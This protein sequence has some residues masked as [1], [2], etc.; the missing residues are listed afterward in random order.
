MAD[1]KPSDL[2]VGIVDFFAILLP[3]AAL[4]FVGM[5]YQR[6]IFDGVILPPLGQGAPQWIAFILSSYLLGHFVFLLGSSI[7]DP[8][9]G[10]SYRKF[11]SL[12]T[13]DLLYRRAHEMKKE[14]LVSHNRIENAYKWSRGLVRLRNSA[15]AAEIDRL[16]A[17]SK[18]FRSMVIVLFIAMFALGLNG[19][20]AL[21]ILTMLLLYF[22]LARLTSEEGQLPDHLSGFTNR[23]RFLVEKIQL[24]KKTSLFVQVA[25][26]VGLIVGA[27][28]W[29][30]TWMPQAICLMLLLLSF[31]CYADQRWKMTQT[32]YLYFIILSSLPPEPKLAAD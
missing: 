21:N 20:L 25:A 26:I 15:A 12:A 3:G 18:F 16:E 24:W 14:I 23:V 31:W 8:I 9:Y 29:R 19:A 28:A 2:L 1:Y 17:N 11:K 32:A 4:T 7:L 27:L 10:T 5:K 22:R 30:T 13:E 6:R